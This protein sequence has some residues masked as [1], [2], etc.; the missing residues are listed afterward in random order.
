MTTS[1]ET[2]Q[3]VLRSH[4]SHA[5]SAKAGRYVGQFYALEHTG[6][7]ISGKVEGNHGTYRVSIQTD[8][9]RVI[10]SACSCYIGK[11]GYCHHCEAL[12]HTYLQNPGAFVVVTAKER[13]DLGK[14]NDVYDYLKTT[15]LE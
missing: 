9:E 10:S 5:P 6:E 11:H 12:A 7:R 15:T 1:P 2:L 4:W 8:G 13:G 14:L 3:T